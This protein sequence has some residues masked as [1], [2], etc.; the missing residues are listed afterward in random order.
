M[1]HHLPRA[2]EGSSIAVLVHNVRR[3]AR[4]DETY[5]NHPSMQLNALI[6]A[7]FGCMGGCTLLCSRL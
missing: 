2:N 7:F 3:D 6:L 4:G 5:I 1:G